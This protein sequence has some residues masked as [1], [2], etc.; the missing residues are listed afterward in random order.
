MNMK[1]FLACTFILFGVLVASAPA[2]EADET[3]ITTANKLAIAEALKPSLVQAEFTLKFDKGESPDRGR[4]IKEER[5]YELGGVVLSD[6]LVLIADPMIHPRFIKDI[7][8]RF[9]E[10]LVA[11]RPAGYAIDQNAMLL[12]L[13]KPLK[14]AKPLK[15]DASGEKPYLAVTYTQRDGD[16]TIMVRS[17]STTPSATQTGRKFLAATAY[18]LIV[19]SEGKPVGM[20]M[21]RDF[22]V[23]DFW[24]GSPLKWPVVS[25][26]KM[27]ELLK[28]L[29]ESFGRGVFVVKLSFR[30]PKKSSRQH[31]RFG[32]G[33]SSS[34][35]MNVLGG[36]IDARRILV[37]ADLKPKLTARLQRI[38]VQ[39]PDDKPVAA[40]FAHTLKDYGAFVAT[41]DKP[42]GGAMV[43][44]GAKITDF[45][46][47]LLLSARV[48]LEGEK[49]T[50][51]FLRSRIASFNVGWKRRIFPGV[52]GS[53][54]SLLLFDTTGRLVAL[55]IVKR[56]KVSVERRWDSGS[57]RLTPAGHLVEVTA[58]IAKHADPSNVP[59]TEAEENRLAW[60]GVV[61]QPLDKELA[62]ISQ[63]SHLT[64]DGRIG[65]LVSYV[66]P[67]S[68]ASAADVKV[69][70]V[71]IRLH[72]EGE[73]KPIDVKIAAFGW[74]KRPFPWAHLDRLPEHLYDQIP[75]PWPPVE[76]NLTRTLTDLGFG[77]KF[78]AVISR[79]G[80]TLRKE[81][82]VTESPPHYDSTAKYKS[83]SL[84]ITVRNMT[85][86]AR[87]YFQKTADDSGVIVSKIEPGSKASVAGVKPFEIITHVNEKPV[88]T[89]GD[90][91]K[92]VTDAGELRLSVKRMTKGRVVKI[93][94]KPAAATTKPAEKTEEQ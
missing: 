18:G 64:K 51:Y 34:T 5:P 25:A 10:Q 48:K 31:S 4:Y 9:G 44:S 27:S 57:A 6:S 86:E 52:R 84:G 67:D 63:V 11:A 12:K 29:E 94:M 73:P 66:Y 72:A 2:E 19:D 60:L 20:L 3:K 46:N 90:F 79:D 42:L 14:G 43:L 8:V 77:K 88:M 78:A 47:K 1:R 30:S 16:W 71:L 56:E 54:D 38:T 7:S 81:F 45:R 82:K 53:D 24:K 13:D 83:K 41:L 74:S 49:C 89:V 61:L 91:E 92:C 75:A 76:N 36:L 26:E 35:E 62:R 87:R 58:D 17:F 39:L 37:L 93:N 85:Y 80:K 50:T 69:G 68:P 59:L 33:D 70:D 65:A 15:F 22:P 32:G 40:K 55:P 21:K 23:G 28:K